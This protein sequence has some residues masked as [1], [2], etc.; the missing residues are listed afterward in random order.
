MQRGGFNCHRSPFWSLSP[1]TL[2]MSTIRSGLLLT[3]LMGM[4][5]G[6]IESADWP[7]FRGPNGSGVTDDSAP[8]S[9]SMTSNLKWKLELP[10]RGVSSP[11]VVGDKVFVT[12]YSGYGIP[13]QEGD[14]ANLK[15][16]LVCVERSNGTVLWTAA[17]PAT[18]PED[19]YTPPGVSAHGYA[20]HTPVC[21]GK[22]VF[23][24]FGKSGVLAFDMEGKQLWQH[25]VG[26]ESGR[27]RWGSAASPILFGD[28][29]IVNAS[30]ESEA[31]VAL[32]QQ[33]GEEKWRA[34][35]SGM[36]SSWS[37]PV[38]VQHGDATELV[39]T[40][41]G[42]VWSFFPETGKLKWYAPGTNDQTMSASPVPGAGVVY[43]IGG[44]GGNSVAIRTGGKGD[45]ADHL[46][47]E[48]SA[49]GRFATPA[50][51]KGYLYT[52]NGAIAL[53]YNA[54]TGERVYQ[55]RLTGVRSAA[56]TVADE[57]PRP[58]GGRGFGGGDYAS[59]I[60]AN[61][62]VYI[63]LKS[64]LV[65]VLEAQPEFKVLATNDLTADSSG[66]DGTP[67]VS[68]GQLFLRS[69]AFLYCLQDE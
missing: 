19:P 15:L 14:I 41:P 18:L 44:R 31:L 63:T 8:V 27:M 67:A 56:P 4:C 35:A 49:S 57:E 12:C 69:H 68:N 20:S 36:A 65:H 30:D 9:W 64:G 16:H 1:E 47:W 52:N 21:D 51:H 60:I 58:R 24:F 26:Q 10:G 3:V 32:D 59:P 37:T 61:G 38:L 40:V 22:R 42:E 11:V 54:A 6:T 46:L 25:L 50:L 39:L 33:T 34:E 7:R 23:V 53:C 45:A 13:G 29:V 48:G 17:V 5:W 2:V 66:F 43:A 28:S 55:D 62:K